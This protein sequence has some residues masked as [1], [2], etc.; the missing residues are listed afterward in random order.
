M[1]ISFTHNET[2]QPNVFEGHTH[3][4]HKSNKISVVSHQG[5]RKHAQTKS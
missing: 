4:V 2:P 3:S 1:V 5:V